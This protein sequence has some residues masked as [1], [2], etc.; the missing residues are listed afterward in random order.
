MGGPTKGGWRVCGSSDFGRLLSGIQWV[1]MSPA[2]ARVEGH[3]FDDLSMQLECCNSDTTFGPLTNIVEKP[4]GGCFD[5]EPPY[6]GR[7]R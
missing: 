3:F 1:K 6:K 5:Q 4:S 7:S 2:D